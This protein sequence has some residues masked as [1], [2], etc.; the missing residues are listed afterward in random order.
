MQ[1]GA[2]KEPAAQIDGEEFPAGDRF[3]IEVLPRVLRLLVPRVVPP[4]P[5]VG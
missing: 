4:E 2:D 1:P 3:R 5:D